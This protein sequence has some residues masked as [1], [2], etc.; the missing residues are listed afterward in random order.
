LSG[1]K[2]S[3]KAWTYFQHGDDEAGSTTKVTPLNLS[4]LLF[5]NIITQRNSRDYLAKKQ[6]KFSEKKVFLGITHKNNRVKNT[7]YSKG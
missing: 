1:A 4:R 5:I 2:H 7:F 3:S 6:A